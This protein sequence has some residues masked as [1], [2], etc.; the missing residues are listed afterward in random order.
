MNLKVAK[1]KIKGKIYNK[2]FKVFKK[3]HNVKKT[4]IPS[5]SEANKLIKTLRKHDG[6]I[7]FNNKIGNILYDLTIILPVYNSEAYLKK[8]IDSIINQ[9]TN[10][11]Y[12][13]KIINDGSTDSSLEIIKRYSTIKNVEILDIKNSGVS[14]ARNTA[15]NEINSEYIMFVDSDDYLEPDCIEKIL[16]IAYSSNYDIVEGSFQIIRN[17][18]KYKEKK[19]ME[20]DMNEHELY[21]FPWNKVYKNYIFKDLGFLEG[22]E[23]EDTINAFLIYPFYK[24]T[25]VISDITYNYRSNYS[26]I[27]F[28]SMHEYKAIDSYIIT[29]YYLK[30]IFE[31]KSKEVN[32]EELFYVFLKQ[33]IKNYK[34]TCLLDKKINEAIFALSIDLYNK[35]FKE[36][37]FKIENDEFLKSLLLSLEKCD[38]KLYKYIATAY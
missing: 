27:T 21:G 1:F 34:R 31:K 16:S 32:I 4:E 11:K 12:L 7:E 2:L 37:N 30:L 13:L 28:T 23:F 25:K 8:C 24:N 14:V 38:Y 9:K 36:L 22:F 5:I 6:N 26:G 3:Y 17:G 29:E 19:H 18:K 15:L 20:N 33:V 10:Y 35:Y